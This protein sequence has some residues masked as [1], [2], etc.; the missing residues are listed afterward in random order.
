[1]CRHM[2]MS[3]NVCVCV[4][5]NICGG[6]L[7]YKLLWCVCCYGV[8]VPPN[9]CTGSL[10]RNA[11]VLGGVV[12]QRGD[13]LGE[14]SSCDCKGVT[15]VCRARPLKQKLL[16]CLHLSTGLQASL[17]T[18]SPRRWTETSSWMSA[19]CHRCQWGEK[20]EV[21]GPFPCRSLTELWRAQAACHQIVC[22]VPRGTVLDEIQTLTCWLNYSVPCGLWDYKS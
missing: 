15:L 7:W 14:H 18:E 5:V 2:Y 20:W 10:S 6:V 11:M 13:C 4:W 16:P 1:M 17:Q 21:R 22:M 19:D 12:Q 8:H 9:S 3:V